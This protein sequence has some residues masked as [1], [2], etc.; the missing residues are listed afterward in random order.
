MA[1]AVDCCG[2]AGGFGLEVQSS[3]IVQEV[4]GGAFCFYNFCFRQCGEA[5]GGVDVA[6]Y[7]DY[8]G[9]RFQL[10]QNFWIANV[11]GVEDSVY[12]LERGFGL[13]AQETV[14]V[15]DQAEEH[16]FRFISVFHHLFLHFSSPSTYTDTKKNKFLVEVPAALPS[17]YSLHACP[18][19]LRA[20]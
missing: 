10:G 16:G 14:S 13:E 18:T 2:N 11:S 6:S 7:G 12:A 3:E 15:G 1:V 4:E 17:I 9:D 5:A 19:G 20:C 8:W